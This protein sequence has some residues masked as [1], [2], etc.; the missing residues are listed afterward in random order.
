MKRWRTREEE[1][2]E[3]GRGGKRGWMRRGTREEEEKGSV[4]EGG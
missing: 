1:V 2:I 4:N 3:D